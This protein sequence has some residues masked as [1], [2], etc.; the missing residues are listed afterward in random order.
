MKVILNALQTASIGAPKQPSSAAQTTTGTGK[1][2]PAVVTTVHT[3][4]ERVFDHC[5]QVCAC[6][7]IAVLMGASC[8]SVNGPISSLTGCCGSYAV[9]HT[10][11]LH[12]CTQVHACGDVLS[13]CAST[14]C[15]TAVT[16]N[17]EFD[18]S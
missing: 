2:S 14:L 17:I 10:L 12:N 8:P 4:I 3:T 15:N 9:Q 1:V 5:Q 6:S 13:G 7:I 11:G 16:A 18:S